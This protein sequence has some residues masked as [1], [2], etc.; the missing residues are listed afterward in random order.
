MLK[1]YKI[2]FHALSIFTSLA[3]LACAIGATSSEAK[4]L[5][6]IHTNDL[7][8]H[9]EHATDHARGGYAAVKTK[10][11]QIRAQAT[12][13]GIESLVLDAGDFSEGSQFYLAGQGENVWKVMDSMGYDAVAIG[14]HDWLLGPKDLERLISHTQ[15][16]FPLLGANYLFEPLYQNTGKTLRPYIETTRN[17]IRI[18][19]LGLTTNELVYSWRAREGIISDPI[20]VAKEY[21]MDLRARNDVVIALTHLGVDKDK[22]L[23]AQVPLDLIVGGHSHTMLEDAI[24]INNPNGHAV[25]IVQTGEHGNFVGNLLV[26]IEKGKP[27]QIIRYQLEPVYN[28]ESPNAAVLAKVAEARAQLE[29]DYGRE[30][31]YETIGRTEDTLARQMDPLQPTTWS[32]LVADTIREGGDG[33]VAMDVNEFSGET[34]APGLLNR[35]QLFQLYPRMFDFKDRFGWTIWTTQVQGYILKTIMTQAAKLGLVMT[36]SGADFTVKM[37][38]DKRHMVDFRINGAKLRATKTYT[39]A[40]AEGL[41]RGAKEISPLLSAVFQETKNTGVPVWRAL[42]KRIQRIGGVI[43][44]LEKKPDTITSSAS[45]ASATGGSPCLTILPAE[46]AK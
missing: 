3:S 9:L 31:L 7:H 28:Q 17:G 4:L 8:S 21:V 44:P 35:E 46:A 1:T 43:R 39:L 32:T 12:E 13:A 29:K 40:V 19:V 26:N 15:P 5:Q 6:I 36:F 18:A 16:K 42:E 2:R 14:N 34:Q 11:E 38:K 23:A 22:Q 41:G 30:Y 25:P 45:G 37:K 10:I 20:K 33:D 27:V 24:M